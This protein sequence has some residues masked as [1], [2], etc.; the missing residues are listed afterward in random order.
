[1]VEISKGSKTF[2]PPESRKILLYGAPGIGK[3]TFF[4]SV[5]NVLFIDTEDGLKDFPDIDRAR[6][7]SWKDVSEVYKMLKNDHRSYSMVVIDTID[8]LVE[9]VR[10][11]TCILLNNQLKKDCAYLGDHGMGG[12][13]RAN[14]RFAQMLSQFATL[15]MGV[16]F[17]SH[18]ERDKIER[19][20]GTLT[21]NAPS[22]PNTQRGQLEAVCDFY[23]YAEI[24]EV[25]NVDGQVDRKGRI[26]RSQPSANWMAKARRR[27]FPSTLRLDWGS[28]CAAY[29][30]SHEKEPVEQVGTG[31]GPGTG[32]GTGAGTGAGT[33]VVRPV[34]GNSP[35]NTTPNQKGHGHGNRI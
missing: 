14:H 7:T 20:E 26:I 31:T 28:F 17:V 23:L 9:Y 29:A 33:H 10:D 13:G 2:A 22:L 3:T 5:P 8:V 15:D 21:L 27:N 32:T 16:G 1:M 25:R 30:S 11:D 35:K 24:G 6:V 4:A 19:P 12:W 34:P 18:W